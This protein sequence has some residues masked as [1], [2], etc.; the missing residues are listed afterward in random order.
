[1][2][3]ILTTA[4]LLVT[5]L[6]CLFAADYYIKDYNVKVTVGNNAVHHIVETIDVYFDGPHHGI[7]REIPLDYSDYDGRIARVRNIECSLPYSSDKDNGYLVLQIGSSDVTYRK[8][9]VSIVLS[10]DYDLGADKNEGYDEFYMNLIGTDWECPIDFVVFSVSIP[11]ELNPAFENFNDF[12][13][14]IGDHTY[15]SSG[16]HGS[17]GF[18]GE[19]YLNES[20]DP[21]GYVM[22]DGYVSDLNAYEGVTMKIDLPD[23]WY[24]GAREMWDYRGVMGIVHPVVT[25][26]LIALA[27]LILSKYGRDKTPIIVARF[28]PPKGFSPLLVGYVA[29][30]TVD[31]KDVI[32]MLFYWADEGLLSIEEKKGDKYEFTK[33]KDIEDYA[34][35]SGKEIPAMEVRLF[36]GFFKNCSVGDTVGFRDLEKNNFYDTILKTKDDTKK[37]FTK[38]R[39]L[40]DPKSSGMSALV[41]FLSLIHV[42]TGTLRNNLFEGCDGLPVIVSLV[43]GVGIFLCNL[44]AF[45][46]LV[47]RWHLRKSNVFA[48]FVAFFPAVLGFIMLCGMEILF[49]DGFSIV[50]NLVTSVGCSAIVL[51]SYPTMRRSDYGNEVLEE[52]LGY[53]E[54][55]EKAEIDQL[56]MMIDSD[57]DFYYKTLS[58]AIVL[59]LENKWAEKFK[60]IMISQPE[61]F[62]GLSPFDV[63]YFS[64][65]S[66]RMTRAIPAASLPKSSISGSPGSR[67]GGGGFGSSG[68]SGGGF[69]GGG[70]HAW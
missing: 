29:D 16:R 48:F 23:N 38:A 35:E 64:R 47:K 53:R 54:F 13:Y 40:E 34:V 68:F 49:R 6:F 28:Y 26:I 33:L 17:T 8:Q 5:G 41:G 39:A 50:Q 70:G 24:Q 66:A 11:Y 14:Y 1:M 21:A 43:I 58:F 4:L 30:N 56:K 12:Y 25:V 51:L 7:V 46:W 10:Y 3:R 59:G 19:A 55:I 57:P 37:Y 67:I 42:V 45:D 69:G 62:T 2:K 18:N 22:V 44:G 61:W 63:Y 32:S 60:G 9:T 20:T 27:L 65:M 52:T 36:N 31:D 15:L